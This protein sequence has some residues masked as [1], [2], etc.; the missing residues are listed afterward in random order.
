[1]VKIRKD[2]KSKNGSQ[3]FVTK[4]ELCCPIVWEYKWKK[5]YKNGLITVLLSCICLPFAVLSKFPIF[6]WAIRFLLIV[7][8]IFPLWRI[9]SIF[10]FLHAFTNKYTPFWWFWSQKY[11]LKRAFCSLWIAQYGHCFCVM[12][13]SLHCIEVHKVIEKLPKDFKRR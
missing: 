10:F 7:T 11:T 13:M 6:L 12:F 4:I 5:I 9:I 8:I 2:T 1:M 3:I